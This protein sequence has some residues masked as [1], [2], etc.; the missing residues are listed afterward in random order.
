V[1]AE[2]VESGWAMI[3]AVDRYTTKR[4]LLRPLTALRRWRLGP[5]NPYSTALM[6]TYD[7]RPSMWRFIEATRANPDILIDVDLPVG[8]VVLDIGAYEGEWSSRVLARADARGQGDLRIHAF[9]PEPGAIEQYRRALG[10]EPRVELHPFGLAGR[11]SWLPLAVGG[12]GSSV[13]ADPA[14]PGYFGSVQVE[15]R[16]VAAVLSMLGTDRIDLVKINIE[17]GEFELLDR[18]HETGWLG[19]TGPVIVQFH[20]FAPGAH[21]A[22]RRNRRQLSETHRCTWCHPW[23]YERWDPLTG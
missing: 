21:R 7:Y 19:R 8:A 5:L 10:D 2:H 23:V 16:D 4:R 12:P 22:R 3:L 6:S 9:E 20:E 11:D 15:L 1:A 13:Y 14:A 18:L 17:G